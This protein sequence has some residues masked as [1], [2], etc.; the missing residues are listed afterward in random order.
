VVSAFAARIRHWALALLVTAA[1]LTT[2]AVAA[3]A[4]LAYWWI[5]S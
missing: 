2:L 1:L 3:L 5:W 4:M